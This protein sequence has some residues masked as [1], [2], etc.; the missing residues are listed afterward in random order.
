VRLL[1]A[2]QTALVVAFAFAMR[3]EGDVV[4]PD[5]MKF[6]SIIAIPAF[7]AAIAMT[8]SNLIVRDAKWQAWYIQSYNKLA[9]E[10]HAVFPGDTPRKP[11][12]EQPVGH[13]ARYIQIFSNYICVAWVVITVVAIFFEFK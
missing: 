11:F 7:G 9:G 4:L 12:K 1:L 10:T 2:A 5:W 8:L 6:L 3:I 13:N